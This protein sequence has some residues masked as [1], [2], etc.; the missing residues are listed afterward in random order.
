M[1]GPECSHGLRRDLGHEH[2]LQAPLKFH[3]LQWKA[4]Y[5]L[6]GKKDP[7]STGLDSYHHK[8]HDVTSICHVV[9]VLEQYR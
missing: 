9:E 5:K 3:W 7:I 1:Q 4:K 2:T 8:F 6:L